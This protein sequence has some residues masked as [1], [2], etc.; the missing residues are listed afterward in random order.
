MRIIIKK[1]K[2]PEGTETE[3]TVIIDTIKT[4]EIT[5]RK[6]KNN[7][8]ECSKF[9]SDPAQNKNKKTTFANCKEAPE[10]CVPYLKIT[11]EPRTILHGDS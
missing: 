10:W 9:F 4:N 11:M 6:E 5:P 2:V 7:T 1:N 8:P 3:R